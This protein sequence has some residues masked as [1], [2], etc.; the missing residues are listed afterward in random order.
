MRP[1]EVL[2]QKLMWNGERIP[3]PHEQQKLNLYSENVHSEEN[4]DLWRTFT[5][6][7]HGGHDCEI[8][9]KSRFQI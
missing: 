9:F 6:Q 1:K 8:C 7:S 3:A 2:L 4:E 5:L